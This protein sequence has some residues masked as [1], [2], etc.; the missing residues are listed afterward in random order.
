MDKKEYDAGYQAALDA[1]RQSLNGQSGGDGQG[2][3]NNLD[4]DMQQP[5]TNGQ[6]GQ[7]G[8]GKGK[9]KDKGSDK[10]NNTRD[11]GSKASDN[12]GVVR[13][14]DCEGS[15]FG[16]DEIPDTAGGMIS[17]EEGDKLAES[18]GYDKEGG[19]SDSIEREWKDAALKN[20]NK[21][22]GK[23]AGKWK[24]MIEGM[25]KTA[26]NWRKILKAIIGQSLSPEDKRSAWANKN[27]LVTQ[28]RFVRTDKDRYD[29]MDYMMAWIDSSGSLSDDQLKL[30]LSEV[31]SVA[32]QKK[33]MKL[34][35]VQCDTQI[36][37]IKEYT[38]IR[39]LRRDI[40]HASVKGR[41]GTELSPCWELLRKNPKYARKRAE[42]VMVF[43]DGYL[44]Q[45]KRDM[46]TMDN[47][48][49]CIIDNP[50]FEVEHQ[51]RCTK[52]IHLNSKDVS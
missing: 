25:Y 27:V 32:N 28:D 29:S 35:V 42:L 38:D 37:E 26:T 51:D 43:T 18:E 14:E 41:G 40:L 45:Y 1:I 5:P 24:S 50:G 47:L 16:G 36:Q 17:K 46:R 7:S 34:V 20:A 49:W 3:D 2:G 12:H 19:S 23:N 52:C 44:K 31:Y 9:G 10:Q 21:I 39:T 6:D 30:I 22:P 13:P 33:P 4:S 11:G 15:G 48:C 8:S